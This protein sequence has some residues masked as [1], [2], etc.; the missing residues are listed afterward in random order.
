[1]KEIGVVNFLNQVCNVWPCGL[2]WYS[3]CIL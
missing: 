3:L 2:T 1:M